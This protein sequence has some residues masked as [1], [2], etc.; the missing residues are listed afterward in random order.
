[1]HHFHII[2]FIGKF[3]EHWTSKY[4]T[5]ILSCNFDI[6]NHYF[7]FPCHMEDL[8]SFEIKEMSTFCVPTDAPTFFVLLYEFACNN[9]WVFFAVRD[10]R[11]V[12]FNMYY[13]MM[14][15]Y[16]WEKRDSYLHVGGL[17]W[18]KAKWWMFISTCTC[19]F[20]EVTVIHM[21][22]IFMIVTERIHTSTYIV[23]LVIIFIVAA[24]L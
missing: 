19:R 9:C 22:Y 12:L 20:K 15:L 16:L 21:I 23:I 11:N 14:H 24:D 2:F 6:P 17:N 3:L 1:M 4:R 10:M 8:L 13:E 5:C 7:P 18:N